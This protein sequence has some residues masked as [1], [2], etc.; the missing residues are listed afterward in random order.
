MWNNRGNC[1]LISRDGPWDKLNIKG[2]GKSKCS[3]DPYSQYRRRRL[4]T[5]SW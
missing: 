1:D 2:N 3:I 4:L 5:I